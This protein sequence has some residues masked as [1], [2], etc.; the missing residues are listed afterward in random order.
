MGRL[1]RG[2]WTSVEKTSSAHRNSFPDGKTRA[3]IRFQG[4]VRRLA[5][6]RTERPHGHLFVVCLLDVVDPLGLNS[7]ACAHLQTQFQFVSSANRAVDAADRSL[8]YV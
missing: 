3:A 5:R 2:L 6:R 7:P 1:S 4:T 8:L